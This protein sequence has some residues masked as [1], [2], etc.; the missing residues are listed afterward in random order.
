[1]QH[2]EHVIHDRRGPQKHLGGVVGLH[3]GLQQ[4]EIGSAFLVDGDDLA[5]ENHRLVHEITQVGQFRVDAE[6]RFIVAAL[7]P[8][9]LAGD[10]SDRADTVPLELIR[11]PRTLG[12]R[13]WGGEHRR[14]PAGERVTHDATCS[15]AA[16]GS[17]PVSVATTTS[18]R[19][20]VRRRH[21][22]EWPPPIRRPEFNRGSRCGTTVE[23]Q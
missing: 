5:V 10:R 14:D 4:P 9:L 15:S 20:D 7:H 12:H 11:P 19:H 21:P 2:V 23:R 16:T 17:I 8:D 13:A 1:V 22:G 6:H 18:R 3:P